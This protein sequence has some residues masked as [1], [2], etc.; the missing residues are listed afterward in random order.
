MA[1][2]ST[3]QA[4]PKRGRPR[5]EVSAGKLIK[6]TSS[7]KQ[8]KAK[9]SRKPKTFNLTVFRVARIITRLGNKRGSSLDSIRSKLKRD[10]HQFKS[11]QVRKAVTKAIDEGLLREVK[12][13]RFFVPKVSGVSS[14]ANASGSPV[15]TT[16]KAST[17][18][19]ETKRRQ[20][21]P[22]QGRRRAP[23]SLEPLQESS[24]GIQEEAGSFGQQEESPEAAPAAMETG[25]G[26]EAGEQMESK[27]AVTEP[28]FGSSVTG[29]DSV[30][31]GNK[32]FGSL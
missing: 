15:A 27:S 2:S 6:T 28:I 31:V 14:S 17:A 7:N 19:S 4:K 30:P 12:E 25:A 8:A 18:G 24:S 5:K 10:G 26:L 16:S 32:V 29:C 9:K 1:S 11:S 21:R 20:R 3:Q 23:A 22:P 13:E